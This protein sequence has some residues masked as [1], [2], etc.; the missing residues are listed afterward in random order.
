[1]LVPLLVC[2]SAATP[3]IVARWAQN[4]RL[5]SNECVALCPELAADTHQLGIK[6]W[7]LHKACG[8]EDQGQHTANCKLHRKQQ[9]N[10]S[11]AR[12]KA[13]RQA[14]LQAV[15][16]S[17]SMAKL[18]AHHARQLLGVCCICRWLDCGPHAAPCLALS[19][20][21]TKLLYAVHSQATLLLL[22]LLLHSPGIMLLHRPV[23]VA[24]LQHPPTAVMVGL[25][26]MF[27]TVSGCAKPLSRVLL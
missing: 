11:S 20:C 13:V 15:A 10:T 1:V 18:E 3:A 2:S 4:T 5:C 22:L 12:F 24:L 27:V 8:P 23:A 19:C 25:T 17:H 16:L 7:W 14:L 21:N 26:W 9:R 6:L